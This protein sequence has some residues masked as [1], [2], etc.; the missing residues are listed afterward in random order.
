MNSV[1]RPRRLAL[2]LAAVALALTVTGCTYLNDTQTHDFYQAADGVNINPTGMGVRNAVLLVD[3]SGKA[4]LQTSVT[5]TTAKDGTVTLVG[6]RDGSTLF[7]VRVDVP[8]QGV[9]PIGG[10]GQQQV[11]ATDIGAKPGDMIEL[12][13]TADGQ[14]EASSPLPVLDRSLEYYGGEGASDGGGEQHSP[15]KH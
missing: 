13:V 4:W 14:E 11:T 10:E 8:A 6:S 2:P 1:R 7:E 12:T 5:N 15:K 3:E 9:T